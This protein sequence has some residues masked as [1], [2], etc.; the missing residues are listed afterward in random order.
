VEELLDVA[1]E[2]ES[3]ELLA[4]HDDHLDGD[5]LPGAGDACQAP[6]R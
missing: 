6:R 3:E 1:I 2:K 4:A 5:A